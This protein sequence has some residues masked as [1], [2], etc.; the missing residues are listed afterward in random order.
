M[1][2]HVMKAKE[3]SLIPAEPQPYVSDAA[4]T[5]GDFAS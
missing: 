2:S 4:V 5:T 3:S 1:Y